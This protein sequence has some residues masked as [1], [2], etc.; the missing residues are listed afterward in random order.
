M[1]GTNKTALQVARAQ[2]LFNVIGGAWPIVWL[3]SF[4]W[5]FGKKED[6]YLQM[7][8]GGLFLTTGLTL[9]ATEDTP[10]SLRMARRLGV[11]AASTYLL[12]DLVYVPKG[13][14]RKTYLLDAVMEVGWL[15][16]WL[17]AGRQP[18]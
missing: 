9:L 12:I 18:R 3:R 14:L 4:E 7:A 2:G 16:A 17:R 11:A 15:W 1:A 10:E 6:D 5:V 8:S 13:R